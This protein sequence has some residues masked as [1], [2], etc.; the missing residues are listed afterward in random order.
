[1]EALTSVCLLLTQ[2]YRTLPSF[3]V[4]YTSIPNIL[5][6]KEF[7][8]IKIFNIYPFP[9]LII[10]DG[11]QHL[12]CTCGGIFTKWELTKSLYTIGSSISATLQDM[13]FGQWMD[14]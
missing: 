10:S 2:I 5:L 6:C 11:L 14:L 3:V 7:M 4:S 8:I 9:K 13:K 12:W 1:M